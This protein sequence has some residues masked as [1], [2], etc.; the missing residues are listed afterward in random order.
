M[1]VYFGQGGPA[2]LPPFG[3]PPIGTAI[4]GGNANSVIVLDS[5]GQLAQSANL[6]YISANNLLCLNAYV[7]HVRAADGAIVANTFV[8]SSDSTAGRR[9]QWDYAN[10]DPFLITGISLTA[11]ASPGDPIYVLEMRG[12]S[13]QVKCDGAG[14]ISKGSVVFFSE[15]YPGRVSGDGTGFGTI[16]ARAESDDAGGIV[17]AL[18]TVH[19]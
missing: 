11:A 7:V 14:T 5:S 2:S 8:K 13:V 19:W 12:Q 9:K 16:A 3:G 10:D 15:L 1:T 6:T 4:P 18:V 17:D